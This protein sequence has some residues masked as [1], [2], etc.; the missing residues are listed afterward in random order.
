MSF[1]WVVSNCPLHSGMNL[2]FS[3]PGGGVGLSSGLFTALTDALS[4]PN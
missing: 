3:W 4:K 1:T 2:S